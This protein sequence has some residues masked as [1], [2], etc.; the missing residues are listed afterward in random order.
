MKKPGLAVIISSPSGTGKTTIC[1]ELIDNNDDFMYSISATT[2]DPRGQEKNGVD[3]LFM[4]PEQFANAKDNNEFIESAE[5]IGNWYGTPQ[6]PL[7]DAINN[8]K[9]VL[10]DIDIQGGRSIKEH[11]PEAVAVFILPP[12][13]EELKKR[14]IGRQTENSKAVDERLWKA[15]EELKAWNEYDYAVVN[16]N[17]EK[18]VN[19]VATIIE[20]ERSKTKR[21]IDKEYW[22]DSLKNLLG[23][24]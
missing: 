14:L 13:L 4:T 12:S 6:K 24:T 22:N 19:Q 1:H 11:L 18:A 3:Y 23:L 10:L 9:V 17:L 16:D 21:K 8:G 2:R 7:L 5:Y 20:V 15:L